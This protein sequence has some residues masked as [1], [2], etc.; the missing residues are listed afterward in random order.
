[1]LG[2]GFAVSR[3]AWIGNRSQWEA[4]YAASPC[5]P[6]SPQIRRALEYYEA[7]FG[8]SALLAL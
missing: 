2:G 5:L 6:A 3:D 4:R 7:S 8:R 1:M